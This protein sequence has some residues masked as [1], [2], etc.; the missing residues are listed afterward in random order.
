MPLGIS[1]LDRTIGGGAPTGSVVLPA[2]E[3]GAGAREFCYT[4]AAMNG[5]VGADPE[6][7]DRYYGDL[8][9]ETTVLEAVHYVP[10][11]DER[12]AREPALTRRGSSEVVSFCVPS[13]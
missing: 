3:S 4:S 10:F 1:R 6:L 13:S 2:V 7:F 11:T 8:E 5:L 12:S 9:P